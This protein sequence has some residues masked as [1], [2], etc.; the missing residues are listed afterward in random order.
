MKKNMIV[1]LM[2]WKII[3]F[4]QEGA[5]IAKVGV[6]SLS[7]YFSHVKSKIEVMKNIWG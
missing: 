2:N 4:D 1:S 5:K 6:W 3:M 7:I